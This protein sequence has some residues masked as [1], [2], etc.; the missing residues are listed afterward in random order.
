V[1]EFAPAQGDPAA[2]PSVRPGATTDH[3]IALEFVR[4]L[5]GVPATEAESAL[6]RQ[7][8]DACTDDTD[9]DTLL[10]VGGA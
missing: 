7:A 5:R 2:V 9:V 10:S 1:L 3:E 4:E 6:L 8:C